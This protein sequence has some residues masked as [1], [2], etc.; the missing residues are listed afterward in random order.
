MIKKNI[1]IFDDSENSIFIFNITSW[2]AYSCGLCVFGKW[3]AQQWYG[4]VNH[5]SK[6]FYKST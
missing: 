5:A 2:S 3:N 1:T 6:M 4:Y